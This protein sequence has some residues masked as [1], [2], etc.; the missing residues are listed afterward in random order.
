[1][2]GRRATTPRGELAGSGLS[3]SMAILF[4]FVVIFGKRVQAGHLPFGML[5]IRFGGQAAILFCVVALMRRPL[6]PARGERMPV[7]LAGLLG[8]GAE[9]A[10]YFSALN[11]GAAAAVTLLF[12]VYPVI[13]MLAS[14]AIDRRA[15]QPM[16]FVALLLALAGSGVVV[17]GGGRVDVEPLGIA[18]ALATAFAYSAY[19]VATDRLVTKTDPLTAAAWLGL[20]ASVAN[21]VYGIGFG[22]LIFPAAGQWPR[23]VGMCV[24]SAGAFASML[25]GLQLIGAVRNAI[26]GVVEP[27]TV[28][29]LAFIFLNEPV[30]WTTA[31]GG[32]L[33][34]GGS[35]IAALVRTT[36]RTSE[37]AVV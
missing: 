34:L 6:L 9:S 33:I 14:I 10:L 37:S 36:R 16:L 26:I 22:A 2:S 17:V 30:R 8:Y 31:L 19:L 7:V 35:V 29:L 32:V 4:A 15:P 25:A 5:T 27:L 3:A 24:F 11:H 20:G 18:L 23:L 13:V 12:Y 21:L 1:M 28:A